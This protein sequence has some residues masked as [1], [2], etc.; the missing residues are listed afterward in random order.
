MQGSYFL[1][2]PA[3]AG[4]CYNIETVTPV[5]FSVVYG[6]CYHQLVST[7]RGL[8]EGC[9]KCK[10]LSP[11][12]PVGGGAVNT[13]DWCIML[14]NFGGALIRKYQILLAIKK[15][16]SF[17]SQHQDSSFLLLEHLLSLY[18]IRNLT[19]YFTLL[20]EPQIINIS[21]G[22]RLQVPTTLCFLRETRKWRLSLVQKICRYYWNNSVTVYRHVVCNVQVSCEANRDRDQ[23]GRG[24]G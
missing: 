15:N 6:G 11:P 12:I 8:Y 16:L 10:S 4:K 1:I 17:Q 22:C 18:K 14:Q 24:C 9:E 19:E 5:R 7:G 20:M 13:N 23:W 3:V 2:V 21:W